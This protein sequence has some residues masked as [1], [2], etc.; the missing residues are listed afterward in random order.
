MK[1]I[2][3][4]SLDPSQEQINSLL[5]YYQNGQYIDAEKLSLSITQEF[6]KHQFAWKALAAV[7]KQMGRISE[8]LV[9]SQKSVQLD[10]QDAEAHNNL[11]VTLKE[12]GRLDEAEA[13]FRQAIEIKPDYAEAHNNL[14]ITLKELGR[15][16]EAETNYKKAIEL[17]PEYAGAHSNLGIIFKELGKLEE[18]ETNYKKAIELKPEYAGAHS[19]L[20]ITLHKLGRLNEAEA[21]YR[22]AIELKPEYAGAHSNLGITLH[23]LGRLNEAEASYRKVIT[24]KPDHSEAHCNLGVTLQELRRFNEAE[25]SFRQAITFKPD[26]AEAKHLLAA[27]T[28]Q[29]T[30]SSPREYVENLFNNHARN[31]EHA[32][33]NKLEYKTPN[34]IAELIV[35]KNPNI[36]LGSVLD[37]GCGTGLVGD[38]IKK[39]CSN[40]EGIDLSKSMLEK[41]SAKNIY[42]KLQHKDIV[43]YLS[44]ENLDFNYF[45]SSDVFIYVGELSEIFKLI[46][47]RNKSKGKFI[48]STEH[49]DRDGFFLEKSGRYSHSKKYIESLC[50][51][52]GY[53]LSHFET[54][55]LRKE[56]DKFI[57]GGLYLLDF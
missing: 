14:G 19:N 39:Y 2:H 17:K 34:L 9:A 31:F 35:A 15:L 51:E 26:F 10:P 46:K 47:S 23:K 38:E 25:A 20:G 54:T 12:L 44:I 33:L 56:K 41:A 37:L 16:E 27:L 1:K 40:L 13:S 48:F 29:T 28:G 32:L 22:K 55:N 43:E 21:S 30:N 3:V 45:I 8:S 49:T 18:A 5:E 52:F 7:L 6:P 50:N 36:Q 24:L 42:D 11:G 57:I 53:K 4:N